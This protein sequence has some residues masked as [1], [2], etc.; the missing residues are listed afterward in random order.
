[1]E[2]RSRN[3]IVL[4]RS[5]KSPADP[6]WTAV[7]A[8]GGGHH[9]TA[10]PNRR[11]GYCML[12]ANVL[13][14][15]IRESSLLAP[16]LPSFKR[17]ESTI[18]VLNLVVLAALLLI[19]T[20]FSSFFG[21]PPRL[22]LIV[23][24]VGFLINVLEFLWIQGA[25]ALSAARIVV[26]TWS[27]I[28][29]NMTPALVPRSL[30]Y[31][32]D[33][34]YFALLVAPILQPAFRFSFW[35]TAAIVAASS[36]L[37]F[38]WV[39][40]YFRL[41]PPAERN[42][43]M[44]AGTISL[45]YVIVGVLVWTLVNHLRSKEAALTKSLVELEQTKER[46]LME[47]KLAAVGRFSS[48]IA[49]E[50]RNPVAM[51]SSALSTGFSG[52]LS[53]AERQEMFEIAAKEAL[54]LEKLTTDFLTYARPQ[55]PVKQP[56]DVAESIAYVADLCR[57]HAAEKSVTIQTEA[58][59]GLHANIDGGQI[60]QALLNL[61][62]NAIEA[63]PSGGIVVLR[64]ARRGRSIQ[65]DIENGNG[66]IPRDAVDRI[67]EPFFTTKQAGTGLGLAIARNIARGHGG[68]L[69]LSRNQPGSIQ[70]SITLPAYTEEPEHS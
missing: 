65:L 36:A 27:S 28:A 53:P 32:H 2:R 9:S 51:I 19:H 16:D 56:G 59:E 63:S 4:L 40:N 46:L 39:W 67:F 34:Q 68:D 44:E 1:M 21:T 17:Q 31:R 5:W 60:Q 10:C 15:L 58:P 3:W 69:V 30:S 23:L 25:R 13:R 62:M 11:A 64:G 47:E 38:F 42:E 35:A 66:P 57:P 18:I 14:K 33:T 37:D 24:A 12:M 41:H 6:A 70:F 45:I 54:R 52:S 22:L 7:V 26:L 55:P 49:H 43:Y 29:L 20:L 50:I 48:A 61:V 8:L